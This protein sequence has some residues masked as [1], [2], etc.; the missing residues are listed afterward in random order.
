MNKMEKISRKLNKQPVEADGASVNWETDNATATT[1]TQKR[2]EESLVYMGIMKINNSKI[3]IPPEEK[4]EEKKN[5]R[6]YLKK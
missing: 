4:V 2:H 1:T 6:V 5:Q 3:M